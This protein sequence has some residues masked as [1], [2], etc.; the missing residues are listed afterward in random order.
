MWYL[1]VTI[2][3]ILWKSSECITRTLSHHTVAITA[4]LLPTV[5]HNRF[6]YGCVHARK[7]QDGNHQAEATVALFRFFS[8]HV[9]QTVRCQQIIFSLSLSDS[10]RLCFSFLI[11][12]QGFLSIN[13]T[14]HLHREWGGGTVMCVHYLRVLGI[15]I[16]KENK[17]LTDE[18]SD[19]SLEWLQN[20][21]FELFFFF[22]K[23]V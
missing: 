16:T 4:E 20:I 3:R 9:T 14:G 5:E 19:L 10:L 12:V 22:S 1:L 7:T 6:L 23:Q 8:H 21:S 2:C 11:F 17:T 18:T 15:T 13:I